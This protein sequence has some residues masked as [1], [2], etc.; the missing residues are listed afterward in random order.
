MS[1]LAGARGRRLK[2]V[3]NVGLGC[4]VIYKRYICEARMLTLILLLEG[5]T[6]LTVY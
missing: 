2:R 4:E 3:L 5:K 6:T 1:L